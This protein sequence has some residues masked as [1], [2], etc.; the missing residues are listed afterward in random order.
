MKYLEYGDVAME[1]GQCNRSATVAN[2]WLALIQWCG[3]QPADLIT[4]G[5][6]C[7]ASVFGQNQTFENLD[8]NEIY[9]KI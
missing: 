9:E 8:C 3:P 7:L 2:S 6:S 4:L 1:V 5:A